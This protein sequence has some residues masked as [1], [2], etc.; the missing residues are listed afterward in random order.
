MYYVDVSTFFS[1]SFLREGPTYWNEEPRD[2]LLVLL[3]TLSIFYFTPLNIPMRTMENHTTKEQR[4]EPWKRALKASDSTPSK[5][6]V[7]VASIMYFARIAVPTTGQQTTSRRG[8][9]NLWILNSLPGQLRKRLSLHKCAAFLSSEPILLAVCC[10][11]HPIYEEVGDEKGTDGRCAGEG[12]G[13][14]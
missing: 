11:P 5:R 7:E 2:Q 6:K 4:I 1:A 13:P 9:N 12:N 8:H 14:F 10:V 3:P